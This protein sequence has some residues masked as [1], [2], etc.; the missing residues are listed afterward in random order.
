MKWYYIE[1]KQA[2]RWVRV[3]GFATHSIHYARGFQDGLHCGGLSGLR[4]RLITVKDGFVRIGSSVNGC[5]PCP[6][7][8]R[9][10]EPV[11]EPASPPTAKENP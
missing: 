6:E 2:G 8:D 4:T 7:L 11:L 1:R 3:R 5:I 10:E 9:E